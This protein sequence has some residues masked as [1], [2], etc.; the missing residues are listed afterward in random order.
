MMAARLRRA[1][2]PAMR[3]RHLHLSD[4]RNFPRLDLSLPVGPAVIVGA[5]AQGKS[6]LL[7]AIHL[8]ATMRSPRTASDAELIRRQVDPPAGPPVG[9]LVAEVEAQGGPLRLEM[10]VA[11]RGGQ[12]LP[13]GGEQSAPAHAGKTVRV[14]GLTRRLSEAVGQLAAVLFTAHDMEMVVGPPSL[15]R[16][17]LDIAISQVDGA[18]LRALQRYAKVLL[19]RNHLLKRLQDGSAR[20]EE[21]AFWDEQLVLEGSAIVGARAL[22]VSTLGPLAAAAHADLSDGREELTLVY[23][24][25]LGATIDGLQ[26]A[27]LARQELAAVFAE[28]LGRWAEREV[29]A[30]ATILGPHRD[31]LIVLLDGVSA[32]AFASRAQQR[33]IALAVRLAE[34]R[35]LRQRRGDSPVLLLD[36]VLSE[37]DARRRAAVLAAV[38]DYEQVVITATDLDRFSPDFLARAALFR[39]AAGAVEPIAG[40]ALERGEAAGGAASP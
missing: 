24:P 17:Y 10:A 12:P 18:Y 19:Q 26:A 11:G 15:R 37:L 25:H 39:V 8:L 22:A 23:Q 13:P 2:A 33:T 20:R 29:R 40:P 9:R 32:A 21:L 27:S 14:N 5:N 35:F 30:G 4:Y 6:N 7:E 3:I 28:E 36:D 31:D 38:A 1:R 16:R 34:A